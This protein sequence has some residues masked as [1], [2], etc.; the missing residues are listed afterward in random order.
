MGFPRVVLAAVASL[1]L[2][3]SCGGGGSGDGTGGSE[4]ASTSLPL[5][6]RGLAIGGDEQTRATD[7]VELQVDDTTGGRVKSVG[8]AST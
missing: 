1:L 8:A 7:I 4:P 3:T 6:S 2:A 5:Q